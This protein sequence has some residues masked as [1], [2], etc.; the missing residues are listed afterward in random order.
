[1]GK[2]DDNDG[3]EATASP[4]KPALTVGRTGTLPP[5]ADPAFGLP[6]ALAARLKAGRESGA[7]DAAAKAAFDAYSRAVGGRAVSG[8]PLPA[9]EELTANPSKAN[10]VAGWKAAAHAAMDAF[11]ANEG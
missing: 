8:H 6:L 9:W 3:L 2:T 5:G 10:V 1:M 4:A 7:S 11:L